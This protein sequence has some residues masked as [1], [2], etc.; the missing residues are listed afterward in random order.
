MALRQFGELEAAIMDRLWRYGR[1]VAV[2]DVVDDLQKDRTIAYTT[3]LTVMDKLHKKGW[4][5]RE[6]A[7][8]GHLY[9]PLVSRETYTARL[10]RSALATSNNQAAA[11]VHFLSELSSDEAQALQ[12]AMRIVSPEKDS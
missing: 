11:F 4:L 5:R 1:P 12:A 7:G 9:E 2:R 3:V 6:K 10:M 8:R